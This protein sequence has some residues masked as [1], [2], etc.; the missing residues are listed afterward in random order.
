MASLDGLRTPAGLVAMESGVRRRPQALR[1]LSD[2]PTI[3]QAAAQVSMAYAKALQEQEYM[4][5]AMAQEDWASGVLFQALTQRA[6]RS[7]D[8]I[9]LPPVRPYTAL[10]QAL[11]LLFLGK[12]QVQGLLSMGCQPVHREA[13]S[14]FMAS[15][16]ARMGPVQEFTHRVLTVFVHILWLAVAMVCMPRRTPNR[17]DMESM[18]QMAVAAPVLAFTP[19]LEGLA[20]A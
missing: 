10:S 9:F 19:Q 14:D 17:G 5:N 12:I 18:L 20:T 16:R 4:A 8:K 1:Q 6:M 13:H 2:M 3:H 7:K 11:A 15:L